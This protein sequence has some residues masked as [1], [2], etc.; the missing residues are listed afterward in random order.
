MFAYGILNNDLLFESD[1]F[2]RHFFDESHDLKKCLS[3]CQKWGYE[4]HFVDE[5]EVFMARD[6]DRG[7]GRAPHRRSND[8]AGRLHSVLD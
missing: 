3:F 2:R 7:R 1:A 6:A 4:L 5:A 8:G